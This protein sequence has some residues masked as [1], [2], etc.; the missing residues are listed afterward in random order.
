M[1]MDSS[2]VMPRRGDVNVEK[3]HAFLTGHSFEHVLATADALGFVT[4]IDMNRHDNQ[5]GGNAHQFPAEQ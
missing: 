2:N 4:S 1:Y 3:G 5:S